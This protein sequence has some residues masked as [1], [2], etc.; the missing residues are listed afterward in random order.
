MVTEGF[1]RDGWRRSRAF[2]HQVCSFSFR[3]PYL[4]FPVTADPWD[5][6]KPSEQMKH[7]KRS[8]VTPTMGTAPLR[9]GA[10]VIFG[11]ADGRESG[12][13]A[14]FKAFSPFNGREIAD[15]Q[16]EGIPIVV[17]P[18]ID[19]DAT[20][21]QIAALTSVFLSSFDSEPPD[22]SS[23]STRA[24]G[25]AAPHSLPHKSPLNIFIISHHRHLTAPSG[26]TCP[27]ACV[28]SRAGVSC[29]FVQL[30][31]SLQGAGQR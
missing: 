21:R 22:S 1:G 20:P 5:S 18:G 11:V 23:P 17:E 16:A 31:M 19:G 4:G 30:E 12:D 9:G 27:L 2:Q 25:H 24:V 10:P 15:I 3:H 14:I 13:R 29:N 8:S 7:P 28:C 6:G 26:P